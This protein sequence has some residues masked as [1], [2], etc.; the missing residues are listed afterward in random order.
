MAASRR[1]NCHLENPAFLSF[2]P[3]HPLPLHFE[4]WDLAFFIK[5]LIPPLAIKWS[6]GIASQKAVSTCLREVRFHNQPGVQAK[7]W[8]K[9]AASS[10]VVPIG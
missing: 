7:L 4:V 5:F 10:T 8:R 9:N 2:L 3:T 1:Q 6:K